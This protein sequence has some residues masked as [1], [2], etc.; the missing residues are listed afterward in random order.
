MRIR[1]L[2][3][4]SAYLLTDG[5]ISSKTEKE[6]TI[7][8]RNKDANIIR[9]F[10]KQ[11]FSCCGKKG[12]I[13]KRKDGTDFVRLHSRK[14]AYRLFELS[15]SYRTK[16]CNEFPICKHLKGKLSSCTLFGTIKIDDIEYPKAKIPEPV[17]RSDKLA[18]EFLRIYASCDGGISVIPAKNKKGS[19]FLV[20]KIF[21]S[22]KHPILNNQITELLKKIGFS[23]SQ[24]KDQVRLVK[25]EDILKFAKDIRFIRGSKISNDSKFLSGFDKNFI[26]KQVVKSYNN[27]KNLLA[28]LQDIRASS[29]LIRD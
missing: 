23:P 24:Y 10:Q 22:V 18:K 19:K 12:Y 15:E 1:Q 14:L 2:V 5:G 27:P 4:L 7:Y 17:F 13:T 3:L 16:A 20:R 29:R 9:E 26:L 8:F 11:L 25:K 21:I 28:F 6:W